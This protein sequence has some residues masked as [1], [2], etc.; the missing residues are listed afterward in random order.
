VQSAGC[1]KRADYMLHIGIKR[2]VLC[3]DHLQE[4]KAT[5]DSPAEPMKPAAWME[6]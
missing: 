4:L 1:Q 6:S 5:L 3:S 2:V